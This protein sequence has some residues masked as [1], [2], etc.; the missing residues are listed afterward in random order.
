MSNIQKALDSLQP[1][2]IGIR[3]IKSSPVVDVVL[4]EGWTI[5]EDPNIQKVKGDEGMNYHMIFSDKPGIGLDELLVYVEKTIKANLDREK[6]HDLLR[7]KV[8]ELKEIFKKNTL[9]KLQRL[10]FS[11][12]DEDLM[13]TIAD[14]DD[15]EFEIEKPNLTVKS[16]PIIEISDEEDIEE[17]PPITYLDE[18]KQPIELSE[19]DKEILAEEAR[20]ERN[21]KAIG[22][23]KQNA[24]ANNVSKKIELP[25]KRKMVAADNEYGTDCECGPAEACEKCIDSKGY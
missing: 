6:K 8:N 24:P 17:T 9:F 19:E 14:I 4:N 2:V 23:R 18:N 3:F 13:P 22:A 12:G 5:L 25:P 16:T 10:K 21:R 7:S 1:Y 15:D 11:F 20:A